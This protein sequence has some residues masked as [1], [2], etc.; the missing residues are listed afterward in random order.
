MHECARPGVMGA[1]G[2][3]PC[4]IGSPCFDWAVHAVLLCWPV[5]CLRLP[6]TGCPGEML[7]AAPGSAAEAV[8]TCHQLLQVHQAPGGAD[9]AVRRCVH[10]LQEVA[11]A[12]RKHVRRHHCKAGTAQRQRVGWKWARDSRLWGLLCRA[13]V[14]CQGGGG[15][16]QAGEGAVP[17]GCGRC[18]TALARLINAANGA[19]NGFEHV[20]GEVRRAEPADEGVVLWTRYLRGLS[21]CYVDLRAVCGAPRAQ[22]HGDGPRERRLNAHPRSGAIGPGAHTGERYAD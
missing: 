14:T 10:L 17:D 7:Q 5:R 11:A 22:G 21:T 16:Q 4:Q 2:L 18:R 1:A 15:A 12:R 13:R 20:R 6:S 8:P 3:P 9:P 19:R